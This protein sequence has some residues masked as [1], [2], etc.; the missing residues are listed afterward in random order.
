[1]LSLS[2]VLFS[3]KKEE[4]SHPSITISS[5]TSGQ[6]FDGGD[7]V[8]VKANVTSEEE[9]HGWVVAIRKL[10]TKQVVF[11]DDVHDHLTEYNINTYWVNNLSAHS[12]MEVE[13]IAYIGHDG[14]STSKKVEFHSHM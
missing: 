3:C 4:H 2:V 13:V 1:M 12:D 14:D 10:P 5:P 9:M 7:T 6:A 11:M 8:Y